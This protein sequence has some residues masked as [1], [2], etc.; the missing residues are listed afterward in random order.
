MPGWV[1][2]TRLQGHDHPSWGAGK[3]CHWCMHVCICASTKMFTHVCIC[4]CTSETLQLLWCVYL[5]CTLLEL[6]K[7][8]FF[9]VQR[10]TGEKLEGWDFLEVLEDFIEAFTV[11][12]SR[13]TFQDMSWTFQ[14][15][16]ENVPCQTFT[17]P[18]SKSIWWKES[19]SP[20]VKYLPSLLDT[21]SQ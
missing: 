17:C 19:F 2:G 21:Y 7:G 10:Q 6:F 3:V 11:Y 14:S 15:N 13:M 8:S 12:T 4:T 20:A 18:A 1:K 16:W 9:Q 5:A